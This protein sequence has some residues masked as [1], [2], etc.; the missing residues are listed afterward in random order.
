LFNSGY[1]EYIGDYVPV[2]PGEKLYGEVYTM[3]ESGASGTAGVFYMGIAQYDKDK[4]PIADNNALDYFVASGETIPTDGVWAKRSGTKTLTTSHAPYGGSDGGPVRYVRPY[5]IVNY[6]SGTIPTYW[7]GAMIRRI[8]PFRDTGVVAFNGNVGIGTTTPSTQLSV[9]GNGDGSMLVGDS[10][11]TNFTG[12]S[13]NGVLSATDYNITSG[14]GDRNL[15]IN[16]PTGY[17]TV[18]REGNAVTSMVIKSGGNVGIGTTTP[19]A[20]LTVAGDALIYAANP[21]LTLASPNSSWVLQNVNGAQ[22][23]I[24]EGGTSERFT[25]ASGGNIGIGTSTPTTKLY[26]ANGNSGVSAVA[27]TALTV[28]SSGN[29]FLS[30]LTPSANSSGV[31]FGNLLSNVDGGIY[32][33]SV[34]SR[35]I[36]FR[37]SGNSTRMVIDANGNVGVG[38]TTPGSRLT[39]SGTTTLVGSATGPTAL[40]VMGNID[41]TTAS[42]VNPFAVGSVTT[43]SSPQ[44][45]AVSGRYAYVANYTSS[46]LQVIDIT[47]PT[48]PLV[49]GSITTGA[50]PQD[51]AVAGS[52]AYIVNYTSGTLQIFNIANPTALSIVGSLTV[53]TNPSAVRVVGKYAYVLNSTSATLQI[54]DISNPASPASVGVVATGGGDPFNITVSGNYAYVT[55]YGSNT[56]KVIDI[57]TPALPPSVDSKVRSER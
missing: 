23:R 28:D 29:N 33:N 40:R 18:F 37:T 24:L 50:N 4:R 14:I 41:N 53:G 46:T 16:R 31:T 36:D 8:A 56:L 44:A 22:F 9:K 10:G 49:V 51:V 7:A 15:Y 39:V 27:G 12:I 5:V 55:N 34:S 48:S 35:G 45:I 25:I 47:N 6:I 1:G 21:V 38:T 19:G 13:L 57:S 20:K 42:T 11:F 2:Q 52:Y 43:G 54:V 26:V 30:L 32:Y 17:E 3:R